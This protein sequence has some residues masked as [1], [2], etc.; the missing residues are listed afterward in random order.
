MN[1]ALKAIAVTIR[2]TGTQQDDLKKFMWLS[3]IL[4]ALFFVLK[5]WASIQPYLPRAT[6]R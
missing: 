3:G 6:I 2:F 5:I 1:R 4:A